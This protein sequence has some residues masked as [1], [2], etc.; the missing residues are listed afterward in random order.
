MKR[1]YVHNVLTN[2]DSYVWGDYNIHT[3]VIDHY[4]K[5]DSMETLD[6]TPFVKLEVPMETYF[7]IFGLECGP[8][9]FPLL[10]PIFDYIDDY[11]AD[12]AHSE[13]IQVK[14]VLSSNGQLEVNLNFRPQSLSNLIEDI[15]AKVKDVCQYCGAT[16]T[17]K[18]SNYHENT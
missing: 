8:F 18:S 16:H 13:K 5:L 15:S 10:Q 12:D 4:A 2:K 14:R 3:K 1:Y 9:W 17:I 7:D 6:M 11:N